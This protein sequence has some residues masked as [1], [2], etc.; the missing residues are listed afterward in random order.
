MMF[1]Y[2]IFLIQVPFVTIV[3]FITFKPEYRDLSRAVVKLRQQVEDGFVSL[4]VADMVTPENA[5]E[6]HKRLDAGGTR[7]RMVINWE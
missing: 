2:P 4:R 3:L 6:A 5:F 1:A 7:G